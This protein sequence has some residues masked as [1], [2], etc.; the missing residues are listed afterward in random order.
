MHMPP[1]VVQGYIVGVIPS[2]TRQTNR[3][4]CTVH[5][6]AHIEY[7]F[8]SRQLDAGIERKHDSGVSVYD[9]RTF[10]TC[11]PVVAQEVWHTH[12]YGSVSCV[13]SCVLSC[14]E[15]HEGF[16]KYSVPERAYLDSHKVYPPWVNLDQAISTRSP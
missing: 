7:Q 6:N 13:S 3:Y 2:G 12:A 15:V 11:K 14:G 9:A 5:S 10:V 8:S 1:G 4:M 16:H